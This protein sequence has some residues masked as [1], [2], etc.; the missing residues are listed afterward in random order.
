MRNN[1][2]LI[3]TI[4]VSLLV[5]SF[6]QPAFAKKPIDPDRVKS[7]VRLTTHENVDVYPEVSPDGSKVIFASFG[8]EKGQGGKNYDLWI[9]NAVTGRGRQHAT[10]FSEDEENPNWYPNGE[11][12]I[13]DS[14]RVEKRDLWSMDVT[15]VS[16]IS[17]VYSQETINFD[18]DVSPDGKSIVFNAYHHKKDIKVIKEGVK[19]KLFEKELPYI[20]MIQDDGSNPT[21]FLQGLSPIWSPDGRKIAFCSNVT[22]NFEIYIMNADG[23]NLTQITNYESDDIEPSWSP[24]GKY[25][26]FT[27]NRTRDWH[28]WITNIEGSEL[29]RL[30]GGWDYHGG[31]SWSVDGSIFFHTNR[32]N[33][34]DIWKLVPPH[35]EKYLQPTPTPTSTQTPTS[36]NT[37]TFTV[38]PT[39]T[40]SDTDG[41]GILDDVDADP[42]Q[43]EDFD[44]FED[45]DG[46]PDPDNDQ[47]GIPDTQDGAPNEP[48]NVNGYK[49]EDGIPDEAPI[50]K[51]FILEGLTFKSGKAEVEPSSV[52]ILDKLYQDMAEDSHAKIE[53]RGYTDNL[54]SIE[55]NLKLSQQRAEAVM[56]Y[57]IERGIEPSR[58]KTVGLGPQNPIADNSTE[59]G[60]RK[61]RRVA[62]IRLN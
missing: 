62:I 30:T 36:T 38:T 43:P 10:A 59:A 14:T 39:P 15:G 25:L 4:F 42:L 8:K 22:G 34:W 5:V 17:L 55:V 61:N 47:D 53:I 27:S 1:I 9:L 20:W 26:V 18:P 31:A 58:M 46:K 54:G 13:F 48:E 45:E 56:Q 11:K 41:D 28:L 44:Q 29:V 50:K 52:S 40:P 51:H 7:I 6:L 23:S 16:G 49:D 60:R 3:T 21:Q 37:P 19:W 2:S 35:V 33:N 24:N 12:I 32:E 57:L